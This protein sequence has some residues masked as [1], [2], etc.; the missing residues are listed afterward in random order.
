MH[1]VRTTALLVL[2]GALLACSPQPTPP[3]PAQLAQAESRRPA[4]PQLAQKYE[5]SCYNCHASAA[6]GAPLSG[7]VA[8][9]APRL[10]RGLPA[11]LQQAQRGVGAMPPRG[12]CSDCSDQE[13]TALI[14]FM[15]TAP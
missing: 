6:S 1:R 15:A 7:L 4:E 12:A 9:W 5:R 13:L 3:T 2:S 14:N 11:L 8:D 10:Q